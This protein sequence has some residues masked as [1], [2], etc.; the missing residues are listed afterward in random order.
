M[1]RLSRVPTLFHPIA[2]HKVAQNRVEIVPEII[3]LDKVNYSFTELEKPCLE[4]T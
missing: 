4:K 1:M 3:F 2:S